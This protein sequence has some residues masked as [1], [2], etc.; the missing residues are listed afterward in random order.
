MGQLAGA[1]LA[2]CVLLTA[3]A[4]AAA[5][6]EEVTRNSYREVV[7]P[8]CR[9]D[10]K[11]NER[12]FAGVRAMVRRDELKPAAA[13]FEKAA[14]ALRRAVSQLRAVPRPVADEARLAKWLRDLSV[15]VSLFGRVA[16][17]LRAGEKAAAER[18]VIR[19]TSQASRANSLVLPFE[20]RYCK[21]E[22]SRFT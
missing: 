21:L 6:A 17:K 14:K 1:G 3:F 10:T 2:T 7:E 4:V 20:F 12:I 5:G 8:I 19:L 11:A 16:T 9:T 15:E 22:P 18:M 13:R